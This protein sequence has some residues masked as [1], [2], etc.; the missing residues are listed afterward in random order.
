[1]SEFGSQCDLRSVHA[2]NMAP[3]ALAVGLQDFQE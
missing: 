3:P 1:M 2:P